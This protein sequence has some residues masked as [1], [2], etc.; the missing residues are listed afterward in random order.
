MTEF[1]YEVSP[2]AGKRYVERVM[3]K[4]EKQS[5]NYYTAHS[6]KIKEYYNEMLKRAELLYEGK[7]KNHP[8]R[9]YYIQQDYIICVASKHATVVSIWKVG[10]GLNSETKS[11]Q[12]AKIIFDD[13]KET[14][15]Q[16]EEETEKLKE[17]QLENK[18]KK[19]LKEI[20]IEQLKAELEILTRE[21]EGIDGNSQINK[22]N[23]KK[24]NNNL[25]TAIVSII[26]KNF[27]KELG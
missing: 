15:L 8:S 20:K 6:A 12:I 19:E 11:K 1:I 22:L 4:P 9:R 24:L 5:A 27:Y 18:K 13:V 7:I 10:F 25:D 16:I 23:L 14:Q 3:G 17:L 2:H 21:V 26:G